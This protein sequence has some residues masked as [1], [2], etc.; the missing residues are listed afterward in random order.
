MASLTMQLPLNNKISQGAV[1]SE[2]DLT[3][4]TDMMISQDKTNNNNN[5]KNH[6]HTDICTMK[7]QKQ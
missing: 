7:E 2:C 1:R 4:E 5:N 6:Q 3:G